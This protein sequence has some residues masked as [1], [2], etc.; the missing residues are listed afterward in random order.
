MRSDT[1]RCCVGMRFVRIRLWFEWYWRAHLV[2]GGRRLTWQ[3]GRQ[4]QQATWRGERETDT[5]ERSLFGMSDSEAGR[6]WVCVCVCVCVFWACSF[7]CS[8]KVLLNNVNVP[9]WR[10][11][12]LSVLNCFW[13]VMPLLPRTVSAARPCVFCGTR[14]DLWH[15]VWAY[16]SSAGFFFFFFLFA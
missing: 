2:E 15:F 9:H 5:E 14:T 7:R 10:A 1:S 3:R 13:P 6:L 11:C 12:L 8:L 16:L 4:Q